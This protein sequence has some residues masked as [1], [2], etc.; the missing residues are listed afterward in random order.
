MHKDV[1]DA[2]FIA[3]VF[4]RYINWVSVTQCFLFDHE[5]CRICEHRW[6]DTKNNKSKLFFSNTNFTSR[7]IQ[8]AIERIIKEIEEKNDVQRLFDYINKHKKSQLNVNRLNENILML[9]I[10]IQNADD[11]NF[12]FFI[13]IAYSIFFVVFFVAYS[14]VFVFSK[15]SCVFEFSFSKACE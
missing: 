13:F 2:I 14:I 5:I 4:W 15:I 1:E 6:Y 12:I 11:N 8:N 7:E 9:L 10:S 3:V